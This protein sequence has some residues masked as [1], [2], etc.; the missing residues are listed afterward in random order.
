[1]HNYTWMS[2]FHHGLIFSQVF[3]HENSNMDEFQTVKQQEDTVAL[4][5]SHAVEPEHSN[6]GMHVLQQQCRHHSQ[7]W[8]QSHTS[9]QQTSRPSHRTDTSFVHAS[10]HSHTH[11]GHCRCIGHCPHS[12]AKAFH[13][14]RSQA[15]KECPDNGLFYFLPCPSTCSC[16]TNPIP[17]ITNQA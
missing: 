1:M 6:P 17:L 5:W 9:S 15:N 10:L 16:T 7:S 13:S 11:S 14:S 3:V 2:V 8:S 12:C 4:L